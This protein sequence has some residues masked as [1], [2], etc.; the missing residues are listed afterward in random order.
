MNIHESR[1]NSFGINLMRDWISVHCS[2]VY[3]HYYAQRFF[4][5]LRHFY[6]FHSEVYQRNYVRAH[7]APNGQFL[8]RTNTC[9]EWAP[10]AMPSCGA[11]LLFYMVRSTYVDECCS[12]AESQRYQFFSLLLRRRLDRII[13]KY[14]RRAE[15]DITH[16]QCT[17][18]HTH[19][20]MQ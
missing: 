19:T 12:D 17:H 14:V 13:L 3:V 5:L 1:S 10:H 20:Y 18:S 4:L 16:A 8:L 9:V 2:T 6:Y 7:I 15:L 11:L